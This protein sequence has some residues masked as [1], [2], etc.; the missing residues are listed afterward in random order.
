MVLLLLVGG[1]VMAQQNG[2]IDITFNDTFPET[3]G[4]DPVQVFREPGKYV[5]LTLFSE[6][7]DKL[8]DYDPALLEKLQV[9]VIKFTLDPALGD[10]A[11]VPYVKL[12]HDRL[13]KLARF[14]GCAQLKYV[15]FSIGEQVYLSDKEKKKTSYEKRAKANLANA[16]KDFGI[17]LQKE[18][19]GVKL[20]AYDWGW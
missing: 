3:F 6:D 9:L 8:A 13:V 10:T 1:R 18:L 12:T 11:R 2:F 16:W 4:N 19:P 17:L 20:Y 5:Y 15:V 7:L 14:R